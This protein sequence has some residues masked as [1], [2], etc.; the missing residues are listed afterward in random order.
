MQ[1][2]VRYACGHEETVT[3][4]GPTRERE[5]KLRWMEGVLCPECQKAKNEKAIQDRTK[6][7]GLPE[8]RGS[9]KQIAWAQTIRLEKLDR[10]GGWADRIKSRTEE[11]SERLNSEEDTEKIEK[12]RKKLDV[13]RDKLALLL[14]TIDYLSSIDESHWWIEHRSDSEETLVDACKERKGIEMERAIEEETKPQMV[15]MEPERKETSTVCTMTTT[16]SSVLIR[17]DKDEHIRLTVKARGFTWDGSRTAWVKSVTEKTGPVKDLAPD[18]ARILLQKG[19]TVKTYPS[20]KDVLESGSYEP[21]CHRWVQVSRE[22]DRLAINKVDE[23]KCYP[24]GKETYRRDFVLV[25]P[26][27]WRE[28]REFAEMHNYKIT[29]KADAML[30]KAEAATVSVIL[31]DRVA[32]VGSA[33]DA[34]KT[35]LESS[36]D[37]L[38]DLKEED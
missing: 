26:A 22:G 4:Y 38:E 8:L 3:L 23:V 2:D 37:V 36:R 35:I 6:E 28:V 11:L 17:C 18:T 33:P 21:E 19:I 12:V 27:L 25:D 20:I 9:E 24:D 30:R 29:K 14:E 34:L 1:Y 10:L 7:L 15:V 31:P 16:D 5:R 32:D 13:G